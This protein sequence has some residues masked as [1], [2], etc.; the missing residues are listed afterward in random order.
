PYA[1]RNSLSDVGEAYLLFGQTS[2]WG[3]SVSLSA[4]DG[5]NGVTVTGLDA[6]DLFGYS[7]SAG[8]I[9]GDGLS[10]MV[11]GAMN[12]DP[13]VGADAGETYVIFGEKGVWDATFDL[14][15]LDG[16]NGFAL[17]G[18]DVGGQS[19]YSLS[20]AG[21]IND[22]GLDDLIIGAPKTDIG[23]NTDAGSAFVVFGQE[24]GWSSNFDLSTL[25]GSNGFRIDGEAATLDIGWK[26]SS[27]GDINGDGVGDLVL[28]AY[29]VDPG[30]VSN[31]GESYVVFG[32][33]SGW[34]SSMALSSLD[35]SNGFRLQGIDA[36][37]RSGA[38]VSLAGDFNSDGFDD[39]LIGANFADPYGND[40]GGE[41]Y[42]IY[43]QSSWAADISLSTVGSTTDGFL[44]AGDAKTSR[45][46]INVD[47]A[48]D[49]NGDGFDDL[50]MGAHRSSP[51]NVTEAGES[52]LIFGSSDPSDDITL[53]TS[54]NDTITGATTNAINAG[55]GD[56]T[57][58]GGNDVIYGGAG[59]DIIEITDLIFQRF[60]GGRGSDALKLATTGLTLDLTATP[61]S[62]ITDF[63]TID[64]TGTG[65]NTLVL[66]ALEVFNISNTTN[67]L[68]IDGDAGDVIDAGSGWRYLGETTI[69]SE[70]Y[71]Q[72]Q[73]GEAILQVDLDIDRTAVIGISELSSTAL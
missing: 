68:R 26:S 60:D 17:S 32:K 11:I 57:I 42:I 71:A 65:N 50:V 47:V 15:T 25:D 44:F 56:D 21:D 46:G 40:F 28:G 48:G 33:S 72:Y 24:S 59:N 64:I 62:K 19:G 54:G 14:T 23:G 63:E 2:G 66:D 5:S 1:D 45:L 30:G 16:S 36:E 49:I 55:D 13:T 27:G 9:N 4:L 52:Y 73:Q 8:D 69:G 6:G 35:G 20:V 43:G 58:S 7:V 61:D 12:G 37:D 70:S 10:D 3:A 41:S 53:G 22:D 67:T 34:S 31:A 18:A 51:D 39:L 38:D 29:K